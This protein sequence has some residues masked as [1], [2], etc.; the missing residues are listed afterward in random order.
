MPQAIAIAEL[1]ELIFKV[2]RPTETQMMMI[3][4]GA[5]RA[6]RAV[7]KD[8][9]S[10]T[11]IAVSDMLDIVDS[12]IVEE[13]DREEIIRRMS[14]GTLEVGEL[15]AAI[16]DAKPEDET[17]VPVTTKPRVRRGSAK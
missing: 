15:M 6:D 8:D 3:A 10:T 1:P 7:K 9:L 4:R 12:L 2:R 16:T 14:M 13:P 11:V 5:V 17:P